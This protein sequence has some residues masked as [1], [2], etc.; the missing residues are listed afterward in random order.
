MPSFASFHRRSRRRAFALL[1]TALVAL[2]AGATTLLWIER[3]LIVEQLRK[4]LLPRFSAELG[5]PITVQSI[6][7]SIFPLRG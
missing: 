2:F 5:R 6:R 7:V 3:P 4:T 1:A